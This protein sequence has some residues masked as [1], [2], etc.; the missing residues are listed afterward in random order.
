[1]HT[2]THT[3]TRAHTSTRAH[4]CSH[5]A[6]AGGRARRDL[7]SRAESDYFSPAG[8]S[9]QQQHQQEGG[10]RD[11]DDNGRAR[12]LQRTA[13]EESALSL[14]VG[15]PPTDPASATAAGA[16]VAAASEGPVLLPAAAD[17]HVGLPGDAGTAAAQAPAVP[18]QTS[19]PA[20]VATTTTT[21]VP[22]APAAP[23][24]LPESAPAPA[25]ATTD[26]E[27]PATRGA[28]GGQDAGPP[29]N[30]AARASRGDS[31]SSV[32]RGAGAEE[33]EELVAKVTASLAPSLSAGSVVV[34]A[35]ADGDNDADE[36]VRKVSDAKRERDV[37]PAAAE[38]VGMARASCGLAVWRAQLPHLPLVTT[39][40]AAAPAK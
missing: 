25:A 12:A 26:A 23:S 8:T 24:P 15:S 3:C 33:G 27:P 19:A 29:A 39:A 1:M 38:Q 4:A 11:R 10:E 32:V 7:L 9:A 30:S 14:S 37:G 6:R 20:S 34:A 17:T 13:S 28:E 5:Q 36:V 18:T 22:T 40:L 21:A 35:G 2:H 31:T 16:H